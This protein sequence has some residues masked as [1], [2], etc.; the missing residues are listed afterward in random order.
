MKDE[1]D[2]K[3]YPSMLGKSTLIIPKYL[4]AESLKDLKS[5]YINGLLKREYGVELKENNDWFSEEGKQI[6]SSFL[7]TANAKK[8]LI[9]SKL[10]Q[11]NKDHTFVYFNLSV[12]T[13]YVIGQLIKWHKELGEALIDKRSL[14]RRNT[15]LTKPGFWRFML[16]HYKKST[17]FAVLGPWTYLCVSLFYGVGVKHSRDSDAMT[18]SRSLAD[19]TTIKSRTN[20]LDFNYY[21]GGE[22][23]YLKAL[24]RNRSLNRLFFD[25]LKN[26]ERIFRRIPFDEDGKELRP[27]S[28]RLSTKDK[29]DNLNNWE[30]NCGGW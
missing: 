20:M 4:A 16:Q 19:A 25:G 21:S 22:E 11:L 10:H 1:L 7:L 18:L 26:Y 13:I 17:L 24:D 29:Y 28:N 5:S 3:L 23:A 8:F 30:I 15:Q 6:I 12:V 9:S 14:E 2:F 27:F